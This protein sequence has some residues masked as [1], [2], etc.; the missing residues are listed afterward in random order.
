MSL[1]DYEKH[2]L[3]TLI[4]NEIKFMGYNF[5]SKVLS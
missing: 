3:E 2:Y 1:F 5:D 4:E